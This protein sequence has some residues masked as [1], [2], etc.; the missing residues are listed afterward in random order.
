MKD[1]VYNPHIAYKAA[2]HISFKPVH[3]ISS[4]ASSR[5]L[6]VG[7]NLNAPRRVAGNIM[8]CKATPYPLWP[9]FLRLR[10]F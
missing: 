4:H 1:F 5:H 6:S 9:T 10:N 3:P 8:E 7:S 2:W